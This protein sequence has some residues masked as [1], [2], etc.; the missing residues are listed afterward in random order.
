[1]DGDSP[2]PT[3]NVTRAG[4]TGKVPKALKRVRAGKA[5]RVRLSSDKRRHVKQLSKQGLISSSAA[6]SHG[7]QGKK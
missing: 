5:K 2:L 6:S 3:S 4:I 1:M 7:L